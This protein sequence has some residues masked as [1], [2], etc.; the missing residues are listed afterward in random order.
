[1]KIVTNRWVNFIL[2]IVFPE[3]TSFKITLFQFFY[4]MGRV[5]PIS[6]LNEQEAETDFRTGTHFSILEVVAAKTQLGKLLSQLIKWNFRTW[7]TKDFFS[8][9]VQT[10]VTQRKSSLEIIQVQSASND[11]L[12]CKARNQNCSEWTHSW[13]TCLWWNLPFQPSP[14]DPSHLMLCLTWSSQKTENNVQGGSWM[15]QFAEEWHSQI[16]SPLFSSPAPATVELPSSLHLWISKEEKLERSLKR[17]GNC[18]VG[19][20]EVG[21]WSEVPWYLKGSYFCVPFPFFFSF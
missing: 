6:I 19:S 21:S 13:R 20:W 9:W 4:F 2:N 8:N 5:L 18:P 3:S 7:C 14:A 10:Q 16:V 1:M 12:F 11:I 15:T 17:A